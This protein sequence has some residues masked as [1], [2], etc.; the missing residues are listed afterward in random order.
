MR[1]EKPKQRSDYDRDGLESGPGLLILS[2][3]ILVSLYIS[4]LYVAHVKLE[5]CLMVATT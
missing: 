3:V 5:G 1:L 4:A 2:T